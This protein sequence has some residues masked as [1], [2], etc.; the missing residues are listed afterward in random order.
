M[1]QGSPTLHSQTF[2]DNGSGILLM[3]HCKVTLER[4]PLGPSAI[5]VNAA[6][7]GN[8]TD[9]FSNRPTWMNDFTT[10]FGI[11]S[12]QGNKDIGIPKVFS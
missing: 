3:R 10:T 6:S 1:C 8:L 5:E 11:V 2:F 7:P 9:C 12:V 4:F